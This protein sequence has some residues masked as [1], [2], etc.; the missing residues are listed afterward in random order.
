[1]A[2]CRRTG[3]RANSLPPVDARNARKHRQKAAWKPDPPELAVEQA[4]N[5]CPAEDY[6]N[7]EGPVANYRTGISADNERSQMGGMSGEAASRALIAREKVKLAD[8]SDRRQQ[9]NL[10]PACLPN[11]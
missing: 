11:G 7:A 5:V 6:W 2:H 8:A 4:T 9:R 3:F 10:D 1:M